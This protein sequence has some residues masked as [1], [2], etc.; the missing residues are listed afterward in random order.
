MSKLNEKEKDISWLSKLEDMTGRANP[1]KT[2]HLRDA[3]KQMYPE[4][5][6]YALI[7]NGHEIEIDGNGMNSDR[8]GVYA[9][10]PGSLD[11][12]GNMDEDRMELEFH[13]MEK[14]D[15]TKFQG[16]INSLNAYMNKETKEIVFTIGISAIMNG[17][18]NNI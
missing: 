6:V 12:S 7:D 17:M 4:Y 2:E 1:Q 15:T 8:Y 10:D 5:R 14:V 16:L 9:F 13:M 18:I 3:M 11:E